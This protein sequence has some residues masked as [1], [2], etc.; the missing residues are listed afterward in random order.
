MGGCAS[1]PAGFVVE[2]DAAPVAAP[3]SSVKA[4]VESPV[5]ETINDGGETG[6]E[7]E[8]IVDVYESKPIAEAEST[9]AQVP[10]PATAEV[11]GEEKVE[12]VTAVE[13]KSPETLDGS[14]AKKEPEPGNTDAPLITI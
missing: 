11:V 10:V 7:E 1:R 5:L 14:T 6:K 3:T 9:A 13:G 4:E 12:A 8:P 2:P